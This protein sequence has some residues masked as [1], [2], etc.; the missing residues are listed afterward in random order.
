MQHGLTKIIINKVLGV[1]SMMEDIIGTLY[2]EN[3]IEDAIIIGPS[4]E[5][6]WLSNREFLCLYQFRKGARIEDVDNF[7]R[8]LANHDISQ[9]NQPLAVSHLPYFV[10]IRR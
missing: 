10:C 7:E 8:F 1:H 3:S 6:E 5:T 2:D 4:Y 9:I